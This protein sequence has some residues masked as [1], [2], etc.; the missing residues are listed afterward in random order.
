MHLQPFKGARD[1]SIIIWDLS[2]LLCRMRQRGSSGDEE[3]KGEEDERDGGGLIR[4]Q[5]RVTGAL[6]VV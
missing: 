1:G 4:V 6:F 5:T 2:R 3:E